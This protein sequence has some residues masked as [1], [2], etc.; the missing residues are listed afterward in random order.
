MRKLGL[1]TLAGLFVTATMALAAGPDTDAGTRIEGEITAIDLNNQQIVV[2]GVTVQVTP[3]TV[4]KMRGQ[5]ILF[6]DLKVGMTVAA[7]GTMEGDVLV[8]YRITVKYGGATDIDEVAGGELLRMS[9]PRACPLPERERIEGLIAYMDAQIVVAISP[10]T[11]LLGTTQSGSVVVHA[12]IPYSQVDVDT[13]ALNDIEVLHT[14]AD[15][16]GNL[17][18]Y[19][20]EAAVKAIVA[21]PSATLTL[22][23]E[24]LDETLFTGSDTVRVKP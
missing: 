19:F 4:I 12:D 22:T 21:P 8:A 1:I 17:V 11:F 20:D 13:L 5:V 3:E 18:A 9:G 10:H 16:C 24:L 15:L 7:C 2:T 23:G 6:G 14:K